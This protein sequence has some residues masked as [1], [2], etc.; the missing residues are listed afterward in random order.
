MN[1]LAVDDEPLA[2]DALT[3]AVHRALPEADIFPFRTG[4]EGLKCAQANPVDVAFLDIDMREMSGLALAVRLKELR[5]ETNIVFITGYSDYALEAM[6]LYASGYLLKPVTPEKILSAMEHLRHPVAR[7]KS[8]KLRV[9]CFGS[10]EVF[11]DGK[12][13]SFP[14]RKSK[15][16]FAYLIDRRG[17][18]VS[19]AEI[20]EALWEDG[21]YDLSRNNQIHS[22]LH[23]LIKTLDALGEKDVVLRQRNAISV[24]VSRVDCD[25]YLCM[26]GSPAAINAYT[27]EYMTQYAWAEFTAGT[28]TTMFQR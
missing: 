4:P 23:D 15:E 21:K 3:G 14:R 5:G 8:G 16:L 11:A 24:D 1:I 25:V 27:G 26:S 18:Q 17:V 28:L 13:V 20:A 19:M 12:P 2:L 6:N 10:F 7:P 22:F 9:Q